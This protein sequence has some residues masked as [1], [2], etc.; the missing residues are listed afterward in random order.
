MSDTEEESLNNE[1]IWPVTEEW[2][3]R[4]IKQNNENPDIS[5]TI[6]VRPCGARQKKV[7]RIGEN[8]QLNRIGF[9]FSCYCCRYVLVHNISKTPCNAIGSQCQKVL[10]VTLMCARMR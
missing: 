6:K 4:I 10:R 2:L 9:V 5:V 7:Q 8:F 1:A 3:S